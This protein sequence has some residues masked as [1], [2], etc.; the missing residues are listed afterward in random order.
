MTDFYN[1]FSFLVAFM[2]F[3]LIFNMIFGG[4]VT[5]KLLILILISMAVFN[6]DLVSNLFGSMQ[7]G[8]WWTILKK[9]WV[10]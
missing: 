1:K 2:V 8:K 7:E 3:I 4:E 10:D 6:T 9:L 5:E